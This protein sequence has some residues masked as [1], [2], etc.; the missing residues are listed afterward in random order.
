MVLIRID[1]DIQIRRPFRPFFARLAI[2]VAVKLHL[3][4][5]IA[6]RGGHLPGIQK[7]LLARGKRLK[8]QIL[9]VGECALLHAVAAGGAGEHDFRKPP[10]VGYL[11]VQ[12]RPQEPH[13]AAGR[14]GFKP[15]RLIGRTV[16]IRVV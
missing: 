4:E 1:R 6:D 10:A 16:D 12:P 7:G 8:Q 3:G 15:K 2:G 5:I 13:P 9:E 11:I 14:I